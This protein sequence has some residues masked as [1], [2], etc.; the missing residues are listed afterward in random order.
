MFNS[1]TEDGLAGFLL[2]FQSHVARRRGLLFRPVT[3][4]LCL[5]WCRKRCVTDTSRPCR[6]SWSCWSGCA[7]PCRRRGTTSTTSSAS[8]RRR[9]TRGPR[10]LLKPSLRRSRRTR[11]PRR[12]LKPSL[13]RPPLGRTTATRRRPWRGRHRTTSQ[14]RR[15]TKLPDHLN[16]TPHRLL[17]IRPRASLRKPHSRTE[18]AST[19]CVCVCVCVRLVRSE[20]SSHLQPGSCN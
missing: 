17:L 1:L 15:S 18:G 11:G 19:A 2:G 20:G 9:R 6:G 13:R 7:E 16:R 5:L 10:R 12:L 8:S 4:N 14:R 3:L